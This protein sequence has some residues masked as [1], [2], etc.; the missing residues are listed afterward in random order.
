ML[1]AIILCKIST[2]NLI[3]LIVGVKIS[4]LKFKDSEIEA[5]K[6]GLERSL[7]D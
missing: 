4:L 1:T 6:G 5:K 3:M 7:N 2:I